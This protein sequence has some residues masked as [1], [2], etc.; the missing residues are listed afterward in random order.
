MTRWIRTEL[1]QLPSMLGKLTGGLA[2][3]IGFTTAVWNA[4]RGSGAA[5]GG[6]LP[7][8][9]LGGAGVALF[10]LAQRRLAGRTAVV[11]AET[12]PADKIRMNVL[13]WALLLLSAGVFLAVSH[14]L[15]W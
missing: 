12:Q 15:A 11:A 7:P 10:L 5:T 1:K 14:I 9:L 6:V 2:A 3:V 13:A 4:T 8:L